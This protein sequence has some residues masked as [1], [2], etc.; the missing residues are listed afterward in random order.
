MT[1]ASRLPVVRSIEEHGVPELSGKYVYADYVSGLLWALDYDQAAGKVVANY[2]LT[3]DK[4]PVMSFGE[5]ET[6]DLYFTTPFGT[7]YRFR[8]GV[9]AP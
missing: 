6:G 9:D 4:L 8:S 5:D 3:G 1:L 7:L 2:S